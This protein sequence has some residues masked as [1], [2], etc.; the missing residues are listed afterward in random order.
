MKLYIY[1]VVI[2]FGR[3]SI[4]ESFDP[5][6]GIRQDVARLEFKIGVIKVFC[7]TGQEPAFCDVW[8][9]V[10][11]AMENYSLALD[12]LIELRSS[13]TLDHFNSVW[14]GYI[15]Q[16]CKG[17]INQMKEDHTE[18]LCKWR[19]KVVQSLESL[20]AARD[21]LVNIEDSNQED[22][23]EYEARRIVEH[24]RGDVNT[25]AENFYIIRGIIVEM[26][27]EQNTKP[28]DKVDFCVLFNGLK[29]AENNYQMAQTELY[30]VSERVDDEINR[31]CA[32]NRYY[33]LCFHSGLYTPPP[34]PESMY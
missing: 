1:I 20:R 12:K 4:A 24:A 19:N 9:V 6:S 21:A 23:D 31:V 5:L 11:G 33:M 8:N 16:H 15:E 29:E 34:P 2:L 22:S 30:T 10:Q 26:I 3:F 25:A 18:H 32:Q 27:C 13:L 17:E 7:D 14:D 28:P